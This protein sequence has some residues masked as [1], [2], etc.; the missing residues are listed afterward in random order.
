MHA[1]FIAAGAQVTTPLISMPA[2]LSQERCCALVTVAR[3]RELSADPSPPFPSSLA[4][5][6]SAKPCPCPSN[7]SSRI[8]CAPPP[9][10]DPF[11]AGDPDE[12][13]RGQ[14]LRAGA[15]RNRQHYRG[16]ARALLDPCVH[17]RDNIRANGTSKKLTHP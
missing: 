10:P 6:R 7:I 2:A 3:N 8:Q 9:S 13:V 14:Q 16:F 17:P 5:T 4:A 12:H 11:P 1:S 15:L